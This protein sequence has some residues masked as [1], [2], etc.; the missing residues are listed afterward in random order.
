MD[1]DGK[2]V[3]ETG[4]ETESI[5]SRIAG[6]L[7]SNAPLEKRVYVREVVLTATEITLTIKVEN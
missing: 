7:I 3:I 5:M 1:Q 2:L 6:I 4:F